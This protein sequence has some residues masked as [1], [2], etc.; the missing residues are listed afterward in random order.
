MM[1]WNMMGTSFDIKRCVTASAMIMMKFVRHKR[2][3]DD[4]HPKGLMI[5]F[6]AT[7]CYPTSFDV[8]ARF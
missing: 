2:N 8:A 3:L 7:F 6:R 1:M 4:A 5:I